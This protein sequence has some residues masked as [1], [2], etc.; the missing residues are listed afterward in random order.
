MSKLLELIYIYIYMVFIFYY[1]GIEC[2]KL[3]ASPYQK[4]H[5]IQQV[6]FKG[7]V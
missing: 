5:P 2:D 6:D 3:L 7:I 4:S 1:R